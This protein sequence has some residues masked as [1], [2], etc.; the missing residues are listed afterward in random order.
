MNFIAPVA[1]G[2]DRVVAFWKGTGAPV[3]LVRLT[4][5]N[6]KLSARLRR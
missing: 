5:T 1:P 4:A 2:V 3:I 6:P